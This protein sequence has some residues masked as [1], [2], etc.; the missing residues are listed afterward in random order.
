M[1]RSSLAFWLLGLGSRLSGN[2]CIFLDVRFSPKGN[3]FLLSPP[4][5]QT[6]PS[7]PATTPPAPPI[8]PTPTTPSTA[9]SPNQPGVRVA[10]DENPNE[11]IP[12]TKTLKSEFR[13]RKP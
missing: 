1:I 9:L 6:P 5:P 12:E 13:R 11:L 7:P 10:Q 4:T 8:P 3:F 2:F